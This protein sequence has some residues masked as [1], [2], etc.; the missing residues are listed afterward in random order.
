MNIEELKLILDTIKDVAQTA[1][2]AGVTWIAVHYLVMLTQ[3]VAVP[4]CVCV[5]LV[6]IT[7]AATNAWVQ[8]K[9]EQKTVSIDA[10]LDGMTITVDG[11]YRALIAQIERVRG[12]GLTCQSSYI[13]SQSVVWL[14][15]AIDARE[16]LDRQK[17][18]K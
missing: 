13:H 14:R 9:T 18:K 5:M 16:E 2:Y 7:R 3:A 10:T 17:G 8:R 4:I 12:K 6:K 1:G 15:E 11:T